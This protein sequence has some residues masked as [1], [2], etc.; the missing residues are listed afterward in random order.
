VLSCAPNPVYNEI[1]L[2][3][4][5]VHFRRTPLADFGCRWQDNVKINLK[6]IGWNGVNGIHVAESKKKWRAV[7]GTVMK[8]WIR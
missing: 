8:L 1:R 3:N 6:E 7:V 4:I 2:N 5:S